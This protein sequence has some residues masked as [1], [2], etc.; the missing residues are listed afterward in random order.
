[1]EEIKTLNYEKAD[2]LEIISNI[3]RESIFQV[4][5]VLSNNK[6]ATELIFQDKAKME[7]IK[8]QLS[9]IG[10]FVGEEKLDDAIL[11]YISRNPDILKEILLISPEIRTGKNAKRGEFDR[12]Y[13]E[14]MGYPK[15]AIEAFIKGKMILSEE[16]ERIFTDFGFENLSFPMR[17][18]NDEDFPDGLK[19]IANWYQIIIDDAPELISYVYPDHEK[20]ENFIKGVNDFIYFVKKNDKNLNG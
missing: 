4:Y 13:G 15:T 11:L 9:K 12:R 1:M 19:Q 14:L 18:P 3:P 5:L 6:L 17:L 7:E 8:E 10:F 16:Q 2:L 20:A